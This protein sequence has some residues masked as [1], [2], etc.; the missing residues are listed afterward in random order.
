[1]LLTAKSPL[2]WLL[3][4]T[5][6]AVIIAQFALGYFRP[7]TSSGAATSTT[8]ADLELRSAAAQNQLQLTALERELAEIRVLLSQLQSS[9]AVQS[10][11]HQHPIANSTQASANDL[12]D[13]KTA[14]HELQYAVADNADLD[15][16]EFARQVRTKAIVRYQNEDRD[17]EWANVEEGLIQLAV[18]NNVDFPSVLFSEVDCRTDTCRLRLLM[19]ETANEPHT[20][21]A[22]VAEISRRLPNVVWQKEGEQLTLL[23]SR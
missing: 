19:D 16:A 4:V 18:E 10:T 9:N 23:L 6:G 8:A 17:S 1:M 22:L 3:I 2:Y 11:H 20:E 14:S 15:E 13:N 5:M 21:L 12:I 7:A